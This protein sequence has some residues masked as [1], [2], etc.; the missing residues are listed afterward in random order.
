M[1]PLNPVLGSFSHFPPPGVNQGIKKDE[2]CSTLT[3]FCPPAHDHWLEDQSNLQA[4]HLILSQEVDSRSQSKL[5]TL[6]KDLESYLGR[7]SSKA[8]S[9]V[10]RDS[11]VLCFKI[12]QTD[13]PHIRFNH[14]NDSWV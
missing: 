14:S 7:N 13:N 5:P 1:Y 8:S 10:S 9:S 12:L 2:S 3:P 6:F 4:V 11:K